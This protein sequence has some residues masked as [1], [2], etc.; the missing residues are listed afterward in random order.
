MTTTTIVRRDS[1]HWEVYAA[2]KGADPNIFIPKDDDP[3]PYYPSKEAMSYCD[4]CPVRGDCLTAAINEDRVGIWGGTTT[5]G[6][7][8]M[9]RPTY[10]V[11]CPQCS[12][13]WHVTFDTAVA[14]CGSCGISWAVA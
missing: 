13:L 10:R 6:R 12:S 8:Q 2:C 4:T 5:Y 1:K 14:I 9:Q 11:K 7:S 3:E